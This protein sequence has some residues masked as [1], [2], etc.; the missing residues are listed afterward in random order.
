M[1]ADSPVSG[2]RYDPDYIARFYDDVGE[3]EWD[4]L[5][6]TPMD[7]VNFAVHRRLL[8][9]FV[10][11]GDRVLEAGAGPGRFTLELAGIGARIVVGDIS[12]GQLDVHREKTAAVEDAIAERV[13]VDIVDLSRFAE[14]EFDATVCFGGPLSYV[15]GEADRALSELLRVTKPGGRVLVTVMSLLGSARVYFDAFPELLREFGWD[16]AVADVFLTGDLPAD[17]NRGHVCRLYRWREFDAL[18]R[19]HP[20]RLVAASASN[21]LSTVW[22]DEPDPRFLELELAACREPGALDGGTH[23]VAAVERL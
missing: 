21:W 6:R 11:A 7:R 17:V 10:R 4:R 18:L 16:R 12:P 9:E 8:R 19:R 13:Q 22:E 2:L 5:D 3:R 20:C 15:L 14:G 1:A 23:I